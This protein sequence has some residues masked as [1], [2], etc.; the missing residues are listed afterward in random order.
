M[1]KSTAAKTLC[2]D[3]QLTTATHNKLRRAAGLDDL[4]D[5]PNVPRKPNRR[6]GPISRDRRELALGI[7]GLLDEDPWGLARHLKRREVVMPEAP[8]T[9]VPRKRRTGF[10]QRNTKLK[11]PGL[12]DLI[13][14]SRGLPVPQIQDLIRKRF[15]VYVSECSIYKIWREKRREKSV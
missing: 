14:S 12:L 4:A 11:N 5:V 6:D 2:G 10:R 1:S 15:D 3:I 7:L 8:P 13:Q 9:K